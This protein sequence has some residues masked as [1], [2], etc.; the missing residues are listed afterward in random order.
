MGYLLVVVEDL[1]CLFFFAWHLL[2]AGEDMF[3]QIRQF[4]HISA[5]DLVA[6]GLI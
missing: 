6:V 5:V 4:S 1:H 3:D 2:P